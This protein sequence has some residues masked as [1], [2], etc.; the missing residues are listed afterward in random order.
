MT[1]KHFYLLTL[2][3]ITFSAGIYLLLLWFSNRRNGKKSQYYRDI[4]QG[5]VFLILAV[6]SWTVVAIYKSFDLKDFTLSY[7][8]N[9]RILSSMNNLFLLSS[10]AFYPNKA[11]NL[12]TPY[13]YK[14]DK[15]VINVFIAFVFIICFFTITDKISDSF[16]VLSRFLI[17][18]LDSIVSITSIVFL[19]Y[20]LYYSLK[21]LGVSK[22]VLTYLNIVVF[23]FSATQIIL[24][25]SKI[26]PN[27]LTPYYP[28]F[29]GLFIIALSQFL[30][31][32]G[33]YY[34]L[35]YNSILNSPINEIQSQKEINQ[36]LQEIIE[37]LS[38]RIGFNKEAKLFYLTINFK[39]HNQEVVEETNSNVKLLQPFLYWLLFSVAKKEH[40]LISNQDIAISK[41][42]MVEYWN[43]ESNYKLNQEIL[44]YNESGNFEFKMDKEHVEIQDFTFFKSKIAVKEIFKKHLICFVDADTKTK[45]Q[46][47]N[48]RNA[49]KYIEQNF[50]NIYENIDC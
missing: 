34:T 14:K 29:L 43:K 2:F 7:I 12:L 40:V 31:L 19:G 20:M 11:K 37:I 36:N 44:F 5:L 45:E 13:L 27:F 15:W 6:F 49:D 8:I 24:P 10:L 25:L 23:L 18:S 35:L 32:L 42:R 21:E 22:N 48:K 3:G 33:T 28:H 9:D 46:L 30:F 17:V 16:S 1:F 26:V 39:D 41:F 50:N 4:N 38:V 47:N